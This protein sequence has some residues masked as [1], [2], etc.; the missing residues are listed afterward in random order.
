MAY[1]KNLYSSDVSALD[2]G[3]IYDQNFQLMQDEIN[4]GIKDGN[5]IVG[6]T[7][8]LASDQNQFSTGEFIQRTTGGDASL[9]DGE[10]DLVLIR[11]SKVHTD[12]LPKIVNLEVVYGSEESDIIVDV[13]DDVFLESMVS[14]SGVFTT[15]FN[16]SSWSYIPS[17]YGITV[18]GTPVE[19]DTINV[20]YR[21]ENRGTITMSN[22]Q[23]FISTGWN[24]YNHSLGYAK[25]L[26]YH[27]TYGFGIEGSYT[28]LKFS[29]TI[30]GEKT[31][32]TVTND[33][34]NIPEDGYIW[35]TGGN[36]TNTAIWMTWSDWQ[37]EANDGVWAEYTE[38]EIDFSSIMSNYFPYGL[39]AVEGYRDEIDFSL[40][41]ATNNVGRLVYNST[42]LELARSYRTAVDYDEDYIYYGLP[43]SIVNNISLDND[44]A[45][46]DHGIEIFTNTEVPVYAQTLYGV[47]LKNKLERDVVTISQQTLTAN[48]KTQVQNNIGVRSSFLAFDASQTLTENQQIQAYSNLGFPS[49]TLGKLGYVV[50][51]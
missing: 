29:S 5:I 11:G 43:V 40:K 51:T 2:A 48:Q 47:N 3:I 34:F 15:V 19:D 46:Y 27:E 16:G 28:S 9:S 6:M 31:T 44:F 13:S 50:V 49:S 18:V 41:K 12:Y 4:S 42:N 8:N 23:S 17:S 14:D 45:A 33:R 39:M 22:P 24:L 36:N 30:D 20:T 21:K 32:I 7:D 10:G 35:V 37:T 25:A 38:D 26:K 1:N